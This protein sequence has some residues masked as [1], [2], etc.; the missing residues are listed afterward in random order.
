MCNCNFWGSTGIVPEA[1]FLLHNSLTPSTQRRYGKSSEYM[2]PSVDNIITLPIHPPSKRYHTG[3]L[4]SCHPS[5]LQL[6]NPI[7]ACSSLFTSKPECQLPH[8][9]TR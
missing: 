8:S 4:K 2:S 6:Q 7:S 3:L 5:N 1:A 9:K